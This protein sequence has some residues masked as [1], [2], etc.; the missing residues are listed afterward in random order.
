MFDVSE[1]KG[2]N[3][4]ISGAT[5]GI[6]NAIAYTL[7]QSGCNL[8]L[9]ATN[10]NAIDQLTSD[11][12]VHNVNIYNASAN[13]SN[14]DEIYTVINRAKK[15]LGSVD[16]IINSAGIFPNVGIFEIEDEDYDDVMNLNFRAAFI[17]TREFSKDMVKSKW[18][19]IVNIGSSSAYFGH[20]ETSLYCA[21]KHALLGF[22]RSIHDELKQFNVRTFCISPSST[23]SKMG[24]ATKGQDYSTFLDPE[25]VA[26][27]VVFAISH[28]SNIV[29]EEIFLKRM[30]VR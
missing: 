18:G 15:T 29:S 19:R 8:F 20:G 21:S 10:Q 22:S 9:T 23:Q 4:F 16:I 25:D 30:V 1:L 27:Y 12:S 13:L 6:G 28:N 17:L 5:G 11:L 3:A 24:L 14:K 2:K 26:K 7:A